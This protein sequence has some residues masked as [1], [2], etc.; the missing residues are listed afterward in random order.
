MA[1]A[2][3]LKTLSALGELKHKGA[4]NTPQFDDLKSAAREGG[5][6]TEKFANLDTLWGP[7]FDGNPN[8]EVYSS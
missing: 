1:F 4:L 7:P 6:S 5:V 2:A 3:R 8:Q